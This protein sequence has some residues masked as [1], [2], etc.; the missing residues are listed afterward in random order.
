MPLLHEGNGLEGGAFPALLK[1]ACEH[2]RN[3]YR[4]HDEILD[5]L[6]SRRKEIRIASVGQV[7]KP[8]AGIDEVQNRSLSLWTRVSMP[9]RKPRIS[10]AFLSGMSSILFS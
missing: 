1:E 9:F 8:P 4:G 7:L 3:A 5:V 10:R 2:L 6:N